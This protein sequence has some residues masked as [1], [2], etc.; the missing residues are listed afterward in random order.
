[1]AVDA[2]QAGQSALSTGLSTSSAELGDQFLNLLITQLKYQDPL[3]PM[4]N[5][6]FISQL[7]QLSSL[8]QLEGINSRLEDN[9][10]MTQSL[11]NTMLV[12]LVGRRV[13]VPGSQVDVTDGEAS[14]NRVAVDRGGTATIE[15]RDANNAVVTT[16]TKDVD[17]GLADISWD[18]KLDDGEV[19]EDGEYKLDITVRDADG[20]TIPHGSY[21]NAPV[22]SIRFI[23]NIGII[24]VGGEEFYI[25]DIQ[26]VSM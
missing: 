10:A 7:S 9:M 17:S 13:T 18:G 8:E 25:S 3:S 22:D 4:D 1:M 21:M 2:I 14:S 26:E 19:A 23:N 20:N 6:Q 12:T 24:E 16:Y 5:Q 15:V 11:N